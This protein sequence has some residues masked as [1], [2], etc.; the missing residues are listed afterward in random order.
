[1]RKRWSG[2]RLQMSRAGPCAA[3][4]ITENPSMNWLNEVKWDAQGLVPVIAQEQDTGRHSCFFSVLKDGA[5]QAID[6]VLKDPESIY[7]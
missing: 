4:Q 7:K 5:W 3:T 6:P 2:K 1:M